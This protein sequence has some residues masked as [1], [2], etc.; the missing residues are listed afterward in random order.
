ME[1]NEKELVSP[2]DLWNFSQRLMGQEPRTQREKEMALFLMSASIH[3][4]V[5]ASATR[6][7]NRMYHLNIDEETEKE[8]INYWKTHTWSDFLNSR[9]WKCE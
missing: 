9:P 6:L 2:N 8:I 4:S 3:R 1:L 7:L 5:L